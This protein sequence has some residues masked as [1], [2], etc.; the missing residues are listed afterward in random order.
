VRNGKRILFVAVLMCAFGSLGVQA[1]TG[2]TPVQVLT[3]YDSVGR[4]I[5]NV[6]GFG[7]AGL[8]GF[9]SVAFMKDNT[10]VVLELGKNRFF[11]SFD[12]LYTSTDC[13]GT[14]FL[15]VFPDFGAVPLTSVAL[16]DGAIYV[17]DASAPPPLL[18]F[19]GRSFFTNNAE[20]PQCFGSEFEY[21]DAVQAKNL[22][23]LPVFT[24]PFSVR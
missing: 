16:R 9:P 10:T 15:A 1:Q 24:P 14:P 19:A 17:P 21:P 18:P 12:L 2:F 7:G 4:R 5:G 6:L 13:T 20:V 8:G 3:A 22:G 23:N 11:G